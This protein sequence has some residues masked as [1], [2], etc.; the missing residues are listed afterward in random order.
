MAGIAP[1]PAS[2]G[3]EELADEESNVSPEEQEQY[4]DFV[5][6]S[7]A[8]IYD[9][10]EGDV[11]GAS[12]QV[13]PGIMELLDDDLSDLNAILKIEPS[14]LAAAAEQ[15]GV[16]PARFQALTAIGATAVVIILQLMELAG[17]ER[18]A[19]A[20]VVH[21]GAAVVEELAEIWIRK[22][23]A[24]LTEDEVHKAF[25]IAADLYREAA[26]DAGLV[27]ENALKAEFEMVA[28]ADR[29]GRLGEISPE[30]EG[31]NRAAE[32]NMQE[33]EEPQEG[34]PVE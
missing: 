2:Q 34:E 11:E 14:E 5:A 29:E 13:R 30:L 1:Q 16:D 21:G 9:Q 20:V 15:Q 3:P 4:D 8:L 25:T 31:I 10:Q 7:L 28:T 27:D 6:A 19:D 26:L 22:N 17:D 33:G 32:M 23:Q 18:P 12:A 24:E